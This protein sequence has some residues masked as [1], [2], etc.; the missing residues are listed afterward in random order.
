MNVLQ[1]VNFFVFS[2]QLILI[3]Y[4][5]GVSMSLDRKTYEFSVSQPLHFMSLNTY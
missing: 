4:F 1:S 2:H 3:K 5:E